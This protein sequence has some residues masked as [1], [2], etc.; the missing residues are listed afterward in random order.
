MPLANEHI[1]VPGPWSHILRASSEIFA[2]SGVKKESKERWVEDLVAL[3]VKQKDG[4]AVMWL[5][6]LVCKTLG[7]LLI[8]SFPRGLPAFPH[9]PTTFQELC[10]PRARELCQ[11]PPKRTRAMDVLAADNIVSQP[12]QS[13]FFLSLHPV[14]VVVI[15]SYKYSVCSSSILMS[16][17]SKR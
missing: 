5:G 16:P 17:N 11:I 7:E 15:T 14:R 9:V 12:L 1:T 3:E 8:G 13:R 10:Q 2:A 6:I 4:A